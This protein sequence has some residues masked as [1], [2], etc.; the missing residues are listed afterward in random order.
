M[1][2][3]TQLTSIIT[4]HRARVLDGKNSAYNVTLQIPRIT[5]HLLCRCRYHFQCKCTSCVELCTLVYSL[6]F[7]FTFVMIFFDVYRIIPS[8]GV[9]GTIGN[10]GTQKHR[11]RKC[12]TE[13]EGGHMLIRFTIVSIRSTYIYGQN[14]LI[15][16]S[17]MAL[18]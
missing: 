2:Y 13:C 4:T 8:L 15:L 7:A 3:I 6:A 18:I 11:K 17:Q 12:N 16:V 9:N 14:I 10:N 5:C 1:Q